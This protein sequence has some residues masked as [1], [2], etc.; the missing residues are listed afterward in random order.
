MNVFEAYP[1]FL[2]FTSVDESEECHTEKSVSALQWK[3]GKRERVFEDD[4]L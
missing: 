1:F 4:A 2:L 3:L